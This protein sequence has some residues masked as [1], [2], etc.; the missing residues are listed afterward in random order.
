MNISYFLGPM[1]N[2][3]VD[4][5]AH[6]ADPRWSPSEIQ[7]LLEEA[8]Q[9]GVGFILQGGVSPQDWERQIEL[10]NQFP[11]QLGLCFGLHPYFVSENEEEICEIALDSLVQVLPRAMAIGELGLDF[12]PQ[13]VKEKRAQQIDF[14]EKQ[15]ELAEVAQLPMVLHLVQAHAE[16]LRI[17]DVWGVPSKKGMV[18][19]FNGTSSQAMDFL[20]RGLYLSL[21]GPLAR[22]ENKKLHQAAAD[23]P[24][25]W[26]LLESDSPDQSP[27]QFRGQRNPPHSILIVAQAL[28]R[29]KGLSPVE[30]LQATTANFHRLFQGT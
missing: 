26:I 14:F 19:S 22:P 15:L 2:L 17:F 30:V 27:P 28:A 20:K 4:A 24:L 9:Q 25:E 29:L 16:A 21:G 5:H 12:R 8:R 10:Q 6:L 7:V 3:W 1:S 11:Q 18:H 23:I 13:I